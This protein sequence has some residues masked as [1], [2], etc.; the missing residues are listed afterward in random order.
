MQSEAGIPMAAVGLITEP[1]QA[2]GIVREGTS[3]LVF[4]AHEPLREPC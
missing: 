1:E 4:P 3:D 2:P